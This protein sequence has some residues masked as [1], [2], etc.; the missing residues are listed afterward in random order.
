VAKLRAALRQAA[1]KASIWGYPAAGWPNPYARVLAILNREGPHL[2]PI[3]RAK[4]LSRYAVYV[5]GL[6][7]KYVGATP[8]RD[9]AQ[10]RAKEKILLHRAVRI[11][12]DYANGWVLLALLRRMSATN[13]H[14][15]LLMNR[16][17]G[18]ALRADPL[19]PYA[20]SMR[21]VEIV[22][23]YGGHASHP[24][25]GAFHGDFGF[26]SPRWVRAFCYRALIYLKYHNPQVEQR[27]LSQ[28]NADVDFFRVALKYYE[29]K[30]LALLDAGKWEPG[31]CPD[32][33]PPAMRKPS[34]AAS[35]EK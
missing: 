20:N 4:A 14:Q 25:A 33:W 34:Q 1:S 17:L 29:P 6:D 12:P 24:K 35:E 22:E 31:P 32:P 26:S 9:P 7:A 21:A 30:Q 15:E 28:P 19:N 8:V 23:Q 2:P 18:R 5:G 16:Y 11:C 27:I 10:Y 3:W 13:L